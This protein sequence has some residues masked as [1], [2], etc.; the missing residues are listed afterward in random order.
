KPVKSLEDLKGLR[1]YTFPTGGQF[2]SKFGVVPVSL[3]YEDVEPAMQTGELDGVC[4]CGITE[5]HTVGWANVLKYYLTNPV[6]GAWAGSYFVNTD[7]WNAVPEHLQ[8]LYRLAIDSSHY[9]RQHWYW[10]GEAKYRNEGKLELTT[11][12]AA[13]WKQVE[14]EAVKFWD[15]VSGQ[16]PRSAKVVE[17]IK[18]YNESMVKAGAPYRYS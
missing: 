18:K 9:Y 12:P 11:I 1:V 3:P 8:Q 17:I 10:A 13:E 16:S 7:K 15:E 14:D 5:M 6:S 2:L 4:W